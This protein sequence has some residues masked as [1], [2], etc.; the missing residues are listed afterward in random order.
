MLPS[1]PD[2]RRTTIDHL[3]V[4]GRPLAKQHL[5]ARISY[6]LLRSDSTSAARYFFASDGRPVTLI[7]SLESDSTDGSSGKKYEGG[8]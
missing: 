6:E 8:I 5:F 3:A 1:T 4:V 7:D 2:A